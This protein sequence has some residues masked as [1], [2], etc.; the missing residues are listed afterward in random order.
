M[1]YLN[2]LNKISGIGP[3]RM[4]LLMKNFPD[5]YSVWKIGLEE[6]QKYFPGEK[7]V[8]KFFLEKKKINPDE[9]WEKL[10]KEN[11]RVISLKDPL[12]PASLKEISNPPYLLYYKGKLDFQN[13]PALAIVG[14]RK[15]TSY[16]AQVAQTFSKKLARL[17]IVIVSGM[18]L[19]IDAFAHKGALESQG[20]TVAVLGNSLD[21]KNLYPKNNINLA[22]LILSQEGALI[23]EY[24]PETPA[25]PLT[26]P[27][28]N[29]I[30]AGLSKGVL[31]VEAGEKS[32]ALITAQ[33]ALD[34]NREVFSVPG[35]IFSDQ[36]IGT[37]SLIKSGAKT[38]CGINDILE[39][40]NLGTE[41]EK[42][43]LPVPN[44][45]EEKLILK[46]FSDEPLHIDKI[47]LLTRLQ[48]TVV[49]GTLTI[50][51]MKGWIKN[52]GGQNYII[53]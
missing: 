37:N 20:K 53:T 35:S 23:S 4:K 49:S 5:S 16:G 38:V 32:G 3:Q 51:E 44:T 11:I 7:L 48:P 45:L 25:G 43:P 28:R 47:I 50:M 30:I 52:I 15:F 18:A 22:H 29:R 10:T 19:G 1:K 17:G 9:E 40:L 12:Y 8:E 36:S 26:F 13:S 31:V 41:K 42:K 21:E 39:E 2:A 14:S 33:M 6:L 46:F 27:A 24:P 34:Y